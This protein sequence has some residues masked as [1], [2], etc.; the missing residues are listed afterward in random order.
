MKKIDKILNQ[1]IPGGAHTYRGKIS[2]YNT[3]EF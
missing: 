3:P 1:V 2:F